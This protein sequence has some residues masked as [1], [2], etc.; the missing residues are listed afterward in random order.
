MRRHRIEPQDILSRI[1]QVSTDILTEKQKWYI[2]TREYYSAIEMNE[3][4][5][6]VAIW[7]NLENI[8]ASERHKRANMVSF[9]LYEVYLHS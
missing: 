4:L 7:K 2:H 8:M 5:I 9:P 3:I 6:H 1:T